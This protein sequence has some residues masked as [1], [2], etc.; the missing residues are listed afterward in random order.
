MLLIIG[1]AD[2][3]AFIIL[4]VYVGAITILFLFVL[5][6]LKLN[7]WRAKDVSV[8][9]LMGLGLGLIWVLGLKFGGLKEAIIHVG[10]LLVIGRVFYDVFVYIFLLASLILL[11]AM[12]GVIIITF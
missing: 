10:N 11:M 4:I 9:L 2:Y 3:L 1:G 8:Y 5:M 6:M 12:A 7:I